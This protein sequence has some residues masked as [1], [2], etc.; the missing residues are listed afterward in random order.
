MPWSARFDD[1]IQ[2]PGRKPFRTLRDVAIFLMN[3]PPRERI[4]SHWLDAI[5]ALI[6][7]VEH[8]GPTMFARI[9]VMR[10]LNR[11]KPAHSRTGTHSARV[12]FRKAAM[13]CLMAIVPAE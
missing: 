3:M 11:G 2:V 4:Q 5:E 10:A 12:G 13:K 6:V 8:N 7:V 9:G 1:P